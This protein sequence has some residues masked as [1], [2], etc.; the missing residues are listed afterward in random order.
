MYFLGALFKSS[1]RGLGFRVIGFGEK[2]L[3]IRGESLGF[4]VWFHAL[5]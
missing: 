4:E 2:L 1:Y 5:G 3:L